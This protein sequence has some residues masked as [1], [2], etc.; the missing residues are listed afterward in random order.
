MK[1]G[2]NILVLNNHLKRRFHHA[3]PP[4]KHGCYFVHWCKEKYRCKALEQCRSYV[5][6]WLVSRKALSASTQKLEAS[7]LAKIFG[8][9]TA[10][11]IKT[12]ERLRVN[13]KRNRGTK[14][15]EVDN[16]IR[17]QCTRA[18]IEV[19]SAHDIRR[20]VASEMDR[21]NIP[22]EDIRWYLG[23]NDIATTRTYCNHKPRYKKG[24]N[25]RYYLRLQSLYLSTRRDSN[26]PPIIKNRRKESFQHIGFLLIQVGTQKNSTLTIDNFSFTIVSYLYKK[27]T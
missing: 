4:K 6:E 8:C 26:I 14:I 13:I 25:R 3:T 24:C 12:D 11:F 22:I 19:K 23:H 5:D 9:S 2:K 20:T 7:S 27:K 21:K 16:C 17:S 1:G 15:R 10:E 18:G